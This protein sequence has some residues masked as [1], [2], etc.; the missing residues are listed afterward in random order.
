MKTEQQ[1]RQTNDFENYGT[2]VH[3]NLQAGVD[4]D[5][6]INSIIVR[7]RPFIGDL[8]LD[9]DPDDKQLLIALGEVMGVAQPLTVNRIS[10]MGRLAIL[11]INDNSWLVL[12]RAGDHESVHQALC[13]T[14]GSDLTLEESESGRLLAQLTPAAINY[15]LSSANTRRFSEQHPSDA[16]LGQGVT[17]LSLQETQDYD[18]LVRKSCAESLWQW[19][20]QNT[21]SQHLF[22]H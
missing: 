2:L 20:Q 22:K 18:I 3:L 4:H 12:P 9:A 19:L 7:E 16:A 17:I 13:E 8:G 10:C 11:W 15:L 1:S 5:H 6:R 21:Q 14:F